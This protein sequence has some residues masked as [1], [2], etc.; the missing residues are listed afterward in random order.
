[1]FCYMYSKAFAP[2]GAVRALQIVGCGARRKRRESKTTSK[3]MRTNGLLRSLLSILPALMLAGYAQAQLLPFPYIGANFTGRNPPVSLGSGDL[4][5]V[6]PDAPQGNWNNVDVS[7][8]G[9]NNATTPPFNDASGLATPVTMTFTA[10]DSWENDG[11]TV[12]PDDRLMF[13]IVKS[14]AS[15]TP[16][17][18]FRP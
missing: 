10:N 11:P 7:A 18:T 2:N 16:P 4:A 3:F 8:P 15:T 13:G 5:G 12:T 9:Y 1:M 14:S 17:V 6:P